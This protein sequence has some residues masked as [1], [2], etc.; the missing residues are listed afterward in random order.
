VNTIAAQRTCRRVQAAWIA[1]WIRTAASALL[2]LAAGLSIVGCAPPRDS[3]E[4]PAP[5][6]KRTAET[7]T[8]SLIFVTLDGVRR[9]EIFQGVDPA[10]AARFKL[11]PAEVK[12]PRDLVP[13][14]YRLFFDEGTVLGDPAL[15]G[16]ISASGPRFVSLPSYLEMMMGVSSGCTNNE[17]KPKMRNTIAEEL[18]AS[19]PLA[20][21]AVF[22]SWE[23]VAR[24]AADDEPHPSLTISAGREQGSVIAAWPGHGAYRPDRVT[25]PLALEYLREHRP[26]FLWI[27][28]GDTD[29]YA[30]H[31]NYPGYLS[32]LQ[33]ADQLLGSIVE[34][35]DRMGEAG[36]RTAVIVTTDH[37]RSANFA[38]HGEPGTGDVWLLARGPSIA[39]AGPIV[40]SAPRRLRDIAPTFRA[41]LGLPAR[42]CDGCGH[43][44][45]ELLPREGV[46]PPT[47]AAERSGVRTAL[48]PAPRGGR[49]L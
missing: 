20:P 3:A 29:E 9:R 23:R 26:R 36:R 33:A 41:L 32:A 30:H 47:F 42:P 22:A 37:D 25:G 1:S 48:A 27:S 2:P 15:G 45:E 39:A 13:N 10:L 12:G 19:S 17:C 38:D 11:P 5:A 34:E 7:P 49:D 16:G 44:I 28:L 31:N 24:A 6:P 8:Q 46:E 40:T 35:L 43:A 14:M 21:S 18:A 4:E